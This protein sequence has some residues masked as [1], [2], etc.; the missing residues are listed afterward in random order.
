MELKL[1]ELNNINS[2][3][4]EQR[5]EKIECKNSEQHEVKMIN[6]NHNANDITNY[7]KNS[8]HNSHNNNLINIISRFFIHNYKIKDFLSHSHYLTLEDITNF[9]DETNL[10]II[11]SKLL[12]YNYYNY[13]NRD[14]DNENN[15]NQSNIIFAELLKIKVTI[16]CL[17][18][19]SLNPFL[20]ELNLVNLFRHPYLPKVCG[21]TTIKVKVNNKST[22]LESDNNNNHHSSIDEKLA[23]H[24][25]SEYIKGVTLKQL[26]QHKKHLL[27]LEILI[28]LLEIGS[29]LEFLHSSDYIHRDLNPNNII[30]SE[31]L[32][33]KFTDFGIARTGIYSYSGL[34]TVKTNKV[35]FDSND[36][37]IAPE[38][39]LLKSE[40]SLK[41]KRNQ[42]FVDG[43]DDVDNNLLDK[44]DNNVDIWAFGQIMKELL[45][46]E[47]DQGTNIEDKIKGLINNSLKENPAERWTINVINESLLEILFYKVKKM[48]N[49]EKYY[50]SIY[51]NFANM[52]Y[53]KK[54]LSFSSKIQ[55]Y[56]IK[57]RS[58]YAVKSYALRKRNSN[59]MFKQVN[60]EFYNNKVCANILKINF[61]NKVIPG[62]PIKQK[63][64]MA[65]L[66]ETIESNSNFNNSFS[67]RI[68]NNMNKEYI[69][70]L[71]RNNLK[72]I[73]K[74]L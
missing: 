13:F 9:A 74:E 12:N 1:N 39:I 69:K 60:F 5:S 40:E 56:L 23:I 57:Y 61:I 35:N 65:Q 19:V 27:I 2:F 3:I 15:K 14:N 20:K 45:V 52:N 62:I 41:K 32:D 22:Q 38:V 8:H 66:N 37:Y 72:G 7:N 58:M 34:K 28:I 70:S 24:I 59:V 68:R 25:I 48:N 42:D 50:S 31:N 73:I 43:D 47:F 30:V 36:V 53:Y 6:Y 54:F 29:F 4:D 16:K 10:L 33:V 55:Y 18:N 26:I 46:S 67:N 49:L 51:K 11:P 63:I 17:A 71:S 21:F 44:L 64:E